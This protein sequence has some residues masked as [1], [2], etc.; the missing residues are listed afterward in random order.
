[1]KKRNFS[2]ETELL[3][4]G[5]HVKGKAEKPEIPPLYLTTAFNADDLDELDELYAGKGYTYIRTRNPN[6]NTL[7]ELVT[8][9]EKGEN[10]LICGSGMAA[11]STALLSLLR[12]GDHILANSTL[13]GE[14]ID[15]FDQVF[16]RYGI[17]ASYADFTASD[18]VAAA[19]KPN[20]KVL[21]TETVSN[22]MITLVDLE[23]LAEIARRHDALLVVDNTFTTSYVIRP[24]EK[25]AA[26]TV[27]SLTKFA[28]GHSDV[29][30]GSITASEA[31]IK[32]AYSLQVLLGTT[33]DPFSAWLCLR[34][35]RTQDLR[36]QKQ[37][38]NATKLAAALAAN[39]HVIRVNHPSLATHPQHQLAKRTFENGYGAMLSFAMP[40]DR[41]K[42][43]AFMRRLEITRYAMT[44]GGMRTTLSHPVTSS[45]H[46]VPE[47]IRRKM[48][49]TYGL[50]R[51][52]VGLENPDDLIADFYQ[53]LAVFA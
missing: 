48:G 12:K 21:Y 52:S 17:E 11:I 4:Q 38:D 3:Y 39:P 40:D 37:M 18:A 36:V 6:R 29:I 45:H 33:V 5:A 2:R 13:Y 46:G 44:L 43:N 53:A 25:G 22:P 24:L 7:A 47:E 8:Y 35:M 10:S 20:T 14:S 42:I 28:N 50:M 30:A 49:I 27:N 1:M 19:I 41:E 31:I 51:V 16:S 34:G 32:K 15:L 23:A 26:V 9:L